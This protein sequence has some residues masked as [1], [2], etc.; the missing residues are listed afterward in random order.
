MDNEK[1]EKKYTIQLTLKEFYMIQGVLE[2]AL[3]FDY[4]TDDEASMERKQYAESLFERFDK[5]YASLLK[6][7]GTQPPPGFVL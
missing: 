3:Y 5:R 7:T 1:K 2:C 4:D 6:K